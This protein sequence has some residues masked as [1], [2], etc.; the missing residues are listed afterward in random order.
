MC[1][2]VSIPVAWREWSEDTSHE[3]PG[4]GATWG[5]SASRGTTCSV[6]TLPRGDAADREAV[7]LLGGGALEDERHLV[8]AVFCV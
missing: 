2:Y 6:R 8:G 1:V 5:V 3:M 7:E 4:P